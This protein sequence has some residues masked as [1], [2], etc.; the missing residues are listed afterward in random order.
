MTTDIDLEL[1]LLKARTITESMSAE[2]LAHER[3]LQ[4]ICFVTGNLL[5]SAGELGASDETA[6]CDRVRAAAGPCPCGRC[7]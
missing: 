1:L 3:H 2:Q 6:L 7:L 4:R 5:L